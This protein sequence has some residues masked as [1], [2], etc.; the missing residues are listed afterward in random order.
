MANLLLRLGPQTALAVTPFAAQL[1]DELPIAERQTPERAFGHAMSAAESVDF[2]K[3][4]VSHVPLDMRVDTRVQAFYAGDF[5]L[6][7]EAPRVSHK[8]AMADETRIDLAKLRALILANAGEGKPLTRRKL[9]MLASGGRNPDLVRNLMNSGAKRPTFE[10]AAGICGALGVDVSTVLTGVRVPTEADDWMEV[11]QTV[12]A[13][14]WR[15][16]I[17]WSP[18]DCFEA[19][20]G[21][22]VVEGPRYGVIVEG[23]SMDRKLPPGTILQCVKLIG[24]SLTPKDGDYV[25]VE[26]KQG[27]LR[28][29][30]CKRLSILP[31]G[32]YQLVA[33]STLPE[34]KDPIPI[35]KP[36]LDAPDDDSQEIRIVAIAV[37]AH[38]DL[39]GLEKRNAA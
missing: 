25:I 4:R 24:S 31:D 37:R 28:E 33:E 12:H 13:G 18:A 32:T 36:N 7:R 26:R 39:F 19:R 8:S 3:D 21:P 14:V 29:L 1:L 5:P 27:A 2:S 22:P 15:E 34:F 6:L 17:D 23:R 20:V 11:C 35:G 16:Q 9:S 10:T 30:T 38:L